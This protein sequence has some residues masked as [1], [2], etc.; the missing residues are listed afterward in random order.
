[1]LLHEVGLIPGNGTVD[2]VKRIPSLLDHIL[3]GINLRK[4]KI[5][6][7]KLRTFYE[8]KRFNLFNAMS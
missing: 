6:R 4:M 3:F 2:E 5:T 7:Y 1:M 8:G